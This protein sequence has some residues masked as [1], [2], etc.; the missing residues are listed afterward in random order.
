VKKNAI[1]AQAINILFNADLYLLRQ[2]EN[3]VGISN[4]P[5]EE[6]SCPFQPILPK[7]IIPSFNKR[8]YLVRL[9]HLIISSSAI[10]IL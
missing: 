5:P 2:N 6:F 8:S 10:K 3:T 4:H 1:T 9:L 7:W